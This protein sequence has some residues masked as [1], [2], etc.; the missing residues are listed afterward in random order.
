MT[1]LFYETVFFLIFMV[2]NPDKSSLMLFSIKA[3]LQ[4][5]LASLA[6][7]LLKTAKK[8]KYWESL[9]ITN[10]TSPSILLALPKRQI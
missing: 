3:E 4:T 10:L 5:D 8:K 1:S 7:L 6:T 2:L 9:L